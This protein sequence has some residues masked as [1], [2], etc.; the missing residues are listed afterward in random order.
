MIQEALIH[1]LCRLVS[2]PAVRNNASSNLSIYSLIFTY[3][4]SCFSIHKYRFLLLCCLWLS[5]PK[6][7]FAFQVT[8]VQFVTSTF[9]CVQISS[10]PHSGPIPTTFQHI[11]P[12]LTSHTPV[13]VPSSTQSC[14][15]PQLALALF[16]A[17]THW[18]GSWLD[19]PQTV[20]NR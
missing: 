5:A 4:A 3:F 13:F 12:L 9:P 6:S 14:Y 17:C 20:V 16:P 11:L 1:V 2:Y 10:Y 7:L 18:L 15:R 19:F 8:F